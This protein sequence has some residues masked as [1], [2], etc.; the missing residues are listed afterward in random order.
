MLNPNFTEQS[1]CNCFDVQYKHDYAI[2]SRKKFFNAY[3]LVLK[4]GSTS[5]NRPKTKSIQFVGEKYKY[6]LQV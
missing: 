1:L 5:K 4:I 6:L 3:D 2:S